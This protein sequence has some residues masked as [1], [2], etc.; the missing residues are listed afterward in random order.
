[1]ALT[2]YELGWNKLSVR[3]GLTA[4]M[5]ARNA[6]MTKAAS[7]ENQTG[8]FLTDGIE[9]TELDFYEDTRPLNSLLR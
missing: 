1:M 3:V 4:D 8:I 5:A 7:R 6:M 9:K 2:A